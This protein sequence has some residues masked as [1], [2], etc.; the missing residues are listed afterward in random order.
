MRRLLTTAG[1]LAAVLLSALAGATSAFAGNKLVL[2]DHGAPFAPAEEA[3]Q[4]LELLPINNAGAVCSRRERGVVLTNEKGGDKL[5]FSSTY[6]PSC[7]TGGSLSGSAK[8][9]KVSA[10]GTWSD[11]FSPKLV[12][13]EPGPCVYTISKLSTTFFKPGEPTSTVVF[14]TGKLNKKE[15]S[16]SCAPGESFEAVDEVFDENDFLL[17]TELRA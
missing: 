7:S 6:E 8:L 5:Q 13:G 10:N 1:I 11:K 4:R 15:S 17:G 9:V 16:P 14:G 12:F 2:T 3:H